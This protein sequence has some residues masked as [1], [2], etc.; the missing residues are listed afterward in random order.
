[1]PCARTARA[2]THTASLSF[3]LSRA[4]HPSSTLPPPHYKAV[5]SR[6]CTAIAAAVPP[7]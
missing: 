3:R 1:M 4:P 6:G 2:R 5:S 7:A